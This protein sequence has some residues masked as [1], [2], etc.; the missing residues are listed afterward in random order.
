MAA[1]QIWRGLQCFL[2]ARLADIFFPDQEV[3][4][5][6]GKLE[7]GPAESEFNHFSVAR[8]LQF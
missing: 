4:F 5:N 2:K 3:S 7:N 8:Q 6:D 1:G